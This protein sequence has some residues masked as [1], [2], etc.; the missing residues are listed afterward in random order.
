M[1]ADGVEPSEFTGCSITRE[2]LA[3]LNATTY[4][5]LP[6][7]HRTDKLLS[8][9]HAITASTSHV[10]PSRSDHTTNAHAYDYTLV[11]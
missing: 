3:Y 9:G 10:I 4:L 7:L 2:S 11:K 8:S 1:M 6:S 5:R